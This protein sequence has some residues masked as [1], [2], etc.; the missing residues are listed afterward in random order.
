M[1]EEEFG[2]QGGDKA[3]RHGA[4]SRAVLV[5]PIEGTMPTSA[6]RLLNEIAFYWARRS[7]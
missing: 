5:L 2:L 4:L 6:R 1:H 3:L 7:E